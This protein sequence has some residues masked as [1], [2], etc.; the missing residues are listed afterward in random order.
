MPAENPERGAKQRDSDRPRDIM[1]ADLAVGVAQRLE[2]GDLFALHGNQPGQHDVQQERRHAQKDRRD[3]EPHR[4]ELRELVLDEPIRQLIGTGN[5]AETAVAGEDSIDGG[6]RF[7]LRRPAH[8]RERRVVER[9][10]HVE[11]RGQCSLFHPEDAESRVVRHDLARTDRV[12][13]FGRQR[14]ADDPQIAPASVDRGGDLVAWPKPVREG[15]RLRVTSTSSPPPAAGRGGGTARSAA[16]VRVREVEI[17]RPVAGSISPGMSSAT[18]TTTRG[19]T[20]AMP[21]SAAQIARRR[22]AARA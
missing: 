19:V 14:D 21:G 1:P 15:E 22:A 16:A 17:S 9:A 18:S 10:F 13:V 6:N 11:R 8:H 2:S 7:G 12:N 3:D 4:L 5:R 20:R